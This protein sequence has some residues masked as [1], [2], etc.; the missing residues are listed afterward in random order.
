MAV[1]LLARINRRNP[2][3]ALIVATCWICVELSLLL[4][5]LGVD[6]TIIGRR[7]SIMPRVLDAFTAAVVQQGLVERGVKLLLGFEAKAFV[8]SPYVNSVRLDDGQ[9]L[10][11][12]LIVAAT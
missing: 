6:V 12:D 11:A 1:E 3:T 5:D 10:E 8:G 7:P 4:A 9:L 2:R